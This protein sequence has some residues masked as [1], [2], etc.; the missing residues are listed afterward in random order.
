V[1]LDSSGA[2]AG[3]FLT[4]QGLPQGPQGAAGD[5]PAAAGRP[6]SLNAYLADRGLPE[7][8]TY[9]RTLKQEDGSEGPGLPE[10]YGTF[11]PQGDTVGRTELGVTQESVQQVQNRVLAAQEAPGMTIQ[12]LGSD[13]PVQR[14]VKGASVGL[15][16]IQDN[17]D[18]VDPLRDA[19][20]MARALKR[21]VVAGGV[22]YPA[23]TAAS[24]ELRELIDDRHWTGEDS[25][26]TSA[27]EAQLAER[28]AKIVE[29][30]AVVEA[31]RDQVE[32]PGDSQPSEDSPAPT[33]RARKQAAAPAS[34]D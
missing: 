16:V 28:D 10:G 32:Q 18:I 12:T 22:V 19:R 27:L 33:P 2:P 8:Y 31:L 20:L 29:L 23:G 5:V 4:T 34:K 9:D 25:G 3:V 24:P 13:N 14:A 30:E 26:D 7:F 15:P 17:E 1:F 11:L 21:S 6:T